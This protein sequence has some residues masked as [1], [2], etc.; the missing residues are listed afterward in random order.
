MDKLEN[1][2]VIVIKPDA[3]QKR[4]EILDLLREGGLSVIKHITKEVPAHFVL[5]NI[6][7]EI[8][9]HIKQSAVDYFTD[10]YSEVVWLEGDENI[11]DVILNLTGTETDPAKCFIGTIR[12]KY[13]KHYKPGERPENECFRNAIHRPKTNEERLK[14]LNSFNRWL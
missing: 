10:G 3:F 14:D 9:E 2:A 1:K 5:E 12:Y 4:A 13:G 8:P 6:I 11:L 7:K